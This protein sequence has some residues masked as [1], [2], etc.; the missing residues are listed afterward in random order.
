MKTIKI[1]I[2]ALALSL[3]TA[4]AGSKQ[5]VPL[6]S[7]EPQSDTATICLIRKSSIIGA[8]NG[9]NV[10]DGEDKVASV[11]SGGY[12]LWE[13]EPGAVNVRVHEAGLSMV[14]ISSTIDIDARSGQVHFITAEATA[15]AYTLTEIDAEEGKSLISKLKAPQYQEK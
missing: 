12:V 6:A 8:A 11:G 1:T 3:L 9:V 14:R 4:C 15:G 10:F 5:Y 7:I 2:A 13:S